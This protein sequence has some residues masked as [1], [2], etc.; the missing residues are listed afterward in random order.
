MKFQKL[1]NL[2]NFKDKKIQIQGEMPI[3]MANA[4]EVSENRVNEINKRIDERQ[5][6]VDKFVKEFDKKKEYKLTLPE[7]NRAN[8]KKMHLIEKRLSKMSKRQ[9]MEELRKCEADEE[10]I[11]ESRKP[12][13]EAE[14][15]KYDLWTSVF[16]DLSVAY[17]PNWKFRVKPDKTAKE[18]RY[19]TVIPNVDDNI[20]VYSDREDD[21]GFAKKVADYYGVE[22][23]EQGRGNR[24]SPEGQKYSAIIRFPKK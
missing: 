1:G 22:F 15:E 11:E 5:K 14:K 2:E 24:Y 17:D 18:H 4:F 10:E 13:K 7:A 3:T 9:L 19:E 23:A 21:F 6:E 8:Y 16:N 12:L 20:V